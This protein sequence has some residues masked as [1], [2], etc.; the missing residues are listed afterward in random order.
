MK[1]PRT[2]TVFAWEVVTLLLFLLFAYLGV[3]MPCDT[4]VQGRMQATAA[5][6]ALCFGAALFFLAA[7]GVR[8]AIF[9]LMCARTDDTPERRVLI[10]TLGIVLALLALAALAS[11]FILLPKLRLGL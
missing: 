1:H 10:G 4:A 3:S 9:H 6:L 11:G 5:V 7:F 2:K 8:R